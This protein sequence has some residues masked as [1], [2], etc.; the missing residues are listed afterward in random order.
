MYP[1]P[2]PL[3]RLSPTF[4]QDVVIAI[5]A[6]LDIDC[7]LTLRAASRVGDQL[8]AA[9]ITTRCRKLFRGMLDD[10]EAFVRELD[11]T[12]SVIGST[13]AL[14]LLYPSTP[15]PDEIHVFTPN[16]LF[17]HVAAYLVHCEHFALCIPPHASGRRGHF[18]KL[19]KNG[20]TIKLVQSPSASP[21]EPIV[22]HWHT[23]LFAYVSARRFCVPYSSLTSQRHGLINPRSL[24]NYTHIP[25]SVREKIHD[26]KGERWRFTTMMKMT[27]WS[28]AQCRGVASIVCAAARRYF[29]DASCLGGP[30]L[31]LDDQ[32]VPTYPYDALEEWTVLWWRSGETYGQACHCEA[33]VIDPGYRV[34]LRVTLV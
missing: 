16:K 33:H 1:A 21:L 12:S 17:F 23:G 9:E 20:G 30:T 7:L 5:S 8:L 24:L 22:R 15:Q 27:R 3:A 10:Y 29:G 31:S 25:H 4:C 32:E 13:A 11:M 34:C 18:A 28:R 14:R 26:W 6:H 19:T 2:F